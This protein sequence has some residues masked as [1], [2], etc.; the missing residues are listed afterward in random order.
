LYIAGAF[1]HLQ[2]KE[3]T[4]KPSIEHCVLMHHTCVPQRDDQT[5]YFEYTVF[6]MVAGSPVK[7]EFTSY[8]MLMDDEQII[9]KAYESFE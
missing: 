7:V 2:M 3:T 1:N 5:T 9:N 6:L 8:P 4:K